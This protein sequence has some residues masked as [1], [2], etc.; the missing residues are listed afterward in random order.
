MSE[1]QCNVTLRSD[2]LFYCE[3]DL[4]LHGWNQQKINH[5]SLS[6]FERRRV[7]LCLHSVYTFN[8]IYKYAN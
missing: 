5:V 8:G 2:I 6:S 7:P 4:S 1:F 3:C